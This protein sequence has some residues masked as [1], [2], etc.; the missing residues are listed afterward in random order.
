M[1]PNFTAEKQRATPENLA[2]WKATTQGDL[3]NLKKSIEDGANPDFCMKQGGDQA[4]GTPSC[5]HSAARSIG[6]APE[7]CAKELIDQGADVNLK[8]ISNLNTPLHLAAANGAL[9]VCKVLIDAGASMMPNAFGNTPLHSATRAGALNVVEYLL[10]QGADP[11]AINN[12][13]STPLHL[14]S[15]L[16][17]KTPEDTL[18]VLIAT[19][20]IKHKVDINVQDV[21]GFTCLHVAS[22]RG[23]KKLVELFVHSGA[24]LT[25]K[26]NID[27]KK[28]GGRTALEMAKFG[29]QKEIVNFLEKMDDRYGVST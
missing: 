2:L 27:E 17:S 10:N 8:L 21:N 25:C 22:Q 19:I 20:L 3:E 9:D 15:F 14:C 18:F 28:R 1:S 12:R 11:S 13:G 5:L 4:D 6:G 29:E 7:E 26:T 16:A 23:I 24:S